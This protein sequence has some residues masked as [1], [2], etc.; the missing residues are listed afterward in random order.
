MISSNFILLFNNTKIKTQYNPPVSVLKSCIRK[1]LDNIF[2]S[3]TFIINF[4]TTLGI[5]SL[6]D[7]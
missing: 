6:K 4:L 5:G 7:E 3:S 2:Q 1:L